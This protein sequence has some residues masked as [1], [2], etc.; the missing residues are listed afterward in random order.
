MPGCF[1]FRRR[2]PKDDLSRK[3]LWHLREGVE[4]DSSLDCCWAERSF[5]VA[6]NILDQTLKGKFALDQLLSGEHI[7]HVLR[8]GAADSEIFKG[9]CE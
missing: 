9:R 1:R 5:D 2:F 7:V 3:P 8:F 6:E 4:V